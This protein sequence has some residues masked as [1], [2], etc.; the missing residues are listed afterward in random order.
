LNHV[1]GP[2]KTK[3]E[4]IEMIDYLIEQERKFDGIGRVILPRKPR[5]YLHGL[6][7]PSMGIVKHAPKFQRTKYEILKT[8]MLK[9]AKGETGQGSWQELA[10]MLPVQGHG[11]RL[12]CWRMNKGYI[13]VGLGRYHRPYLWRTPSKK[14]R[15]L[16]KARR[17]VRRMEREQPEL[18]RMWCLELTAYWKQL[19]EINAKVATGRRNWIRS[20]IQKGIKP[21]GVT[22]K[23][24]K[25]VMSEVVK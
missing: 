18:T 6:Q 21:K 22:R 4:G 12:S 5:E 19:K 23:E 20:C 17:F 16:N 24:L 11:V 10:K 9:E 2:G 15:L 8:L 3:H 14:Y 1:T 7:D 13:D 25:E